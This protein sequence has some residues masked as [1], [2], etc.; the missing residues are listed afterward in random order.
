VPTGGRRQWGKTRLPDDAAEKAAIARARRRTTT[1][2]SDAADAYRAW[3]PAVLGYIR[4]QRVA[5]PEDV[6]GEVFLQV[7]RDLDSFEGGEADLRRWVFT[8][9]R[10]R[11]IDRQRRAT[12]RPEVLVVELPVEADEP[13]PDPVDPTLVEALGRLSE[14]QR[15]VLL[16]RFVA[17][18]PLED[19][20]TLTDRSIGAIK[21]L[22]H[23]GLQRLRRD[24]AVAGTT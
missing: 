15:E 16:L 11:V 6:L 8:I 20:A 23:R 17:D 13:P 2:I 18:L 7:S 12:R 14:D 1:G 22:Q 10:N 9:A 21:A 24:E 5:D 19:V 4:G 3:A